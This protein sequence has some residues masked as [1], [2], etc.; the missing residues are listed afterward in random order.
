M[1]LLIRI[2]RRCDKSGDPFD[3]TRVHLYSICIVLHTHGKHEIFVSKVEAFASI[4]EIILDGL[5]H[6]WPQAQKHELEFQQG[7]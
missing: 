1:D 7:E 6:V 3:V 5:Y 2:R 4:E